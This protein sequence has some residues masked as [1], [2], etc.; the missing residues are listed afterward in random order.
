MTDGIGVYS[1]LSTFENCLAWETPKMKK[2]I[3]ILQNYFLFASVSIKLCISFNFKKKWQA[4]KNL[5]K[6]TNKKQNKNRLCQL[7]LWCRRFCMR[8]GM[9]CID[10]DF[11]FLAWE[12]VSRCEIHAQCV[13]VDSPGLLC[14]ALNSKVQSYFFSFMPID[15]RRT[16]CYIHYTS[17]FWHYALSFKIW[18]I[19]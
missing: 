12:M 8:V 2:K 6:K 16:A 9:F 17:A 3:I 15:N 13:R 4:K 5:K 18:S 19:M 10:A 11:I 7:F 14:K 1:G